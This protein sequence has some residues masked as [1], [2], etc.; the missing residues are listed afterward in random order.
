MDDNRRSERVSEEVKIEEIDLCSPEN[1]KGKSE[2]IISVSNSYSGSHKN[3]ARA[4]RS[5]KF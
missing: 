3:K 2:S 1:S 4:K 5:E